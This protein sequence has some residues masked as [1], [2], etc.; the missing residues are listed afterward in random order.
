MTQSKRTHIGP[1]DII[2]SMLG[3]MVYLVVGIVAG[4]ALGYWLAYYAIGLLPLLIL[5]AVLCGDGIVWLSWG[6]GPKNTLG[7]MTISTYGTCY[8][9]SI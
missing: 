7:H 3:N 2:D 5:A 8:F 4:V 1:S 6:Q 9:V